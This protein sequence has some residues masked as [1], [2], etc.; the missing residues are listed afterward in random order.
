[1]PLHVL[2]CVRRV[3]RIDPN[4]IH[5]AIARKFADDKIAHG[6]DRTNG[7]SPCVEVCEKPI[8]CFHAVICLNNAS[9]GQDI[10]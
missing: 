10:Y 8:L 5:S 2:N 9:K 7:R 3:F 6:H 4:E 1:M